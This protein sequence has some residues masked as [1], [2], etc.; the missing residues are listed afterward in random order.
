MDNAGK[1]WVVINVT[2]KPDKARKVMNDALTFDL[3]A[4]T[5]VYR[6]ALELTDSEMKIFN[7]IVHHIRHG[8]NV[9]PTAT[10]QQVHYKIWDYWRTRRITQHLSESMVFRLLA[11]CES[12]NPDRANRSWYQDA[13][14]Q[15]RAKQVD[16]DTVAAT[17][18]IAYAKE[19]FAAAGVDDS[20]VLV[21]P[22]HTDD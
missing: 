22:P 2:G 20:L 4:N 14:K 19:M 1:Q 5:D 17:L 8:G 9:L 11:A 15:I 16:F 3:L 6:E 10:S 21:Q 18:G 13:L 7:L 12:D